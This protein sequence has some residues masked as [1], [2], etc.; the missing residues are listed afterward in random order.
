MGAFV[1]DEA[2][3]T[4]DGHGDTGTRRGQDDHVCVWED[5]LVRAQAEDAAVDAFGA[6]EC[7]GV[8]AFFSFSFLYRFLDVGGVLWDD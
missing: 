3:L 1:G 8:S 5:P 6:G 7:L 4:F 2:V